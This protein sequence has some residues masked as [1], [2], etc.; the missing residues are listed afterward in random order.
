MLFFYKNKKYLKSLLIAILFFDIFF[1]SPIHKTIAQMEGFG[2]AVSNLGNTGGALGMPAAGVSESGLGLGSTAAPTG[3][4]VQDKMGIFQRVLKTIRDSW[5]QMGVTLHN[6]ADSVKEYIL[7]PLV[8]TAANVI[9]DKFSDSLVTWIQ[10]GFEGSPMFLSDPEGF[11]KDTANDISGAIIND[12]NMNWLCDSLG[13][14][15][16]DLTFFLPGTSR[17]EYACTFEDIANNFKDIASRDELGDWV[18]VN[19]D[20]N[21]QNIVRRFGDD[22]RNGGFWMWLATPLPKNNQTGRIMTGWEKAAIASEEAK[23]RGKFGLSINGGF[24]GMRKCV[25]YEDIQ[26]AM[27]NNKEAEC[28][29]YVNTTP[30]SL[31]QDQLNNSA[32]KDLARLQVA[33]EIDEIIGA[34]ATTM[35]GWLLT[36]GNNNEGVLGYDSGAEYSGS[37]RD[38]YGELSKS[39]KLT[40]AKSNISNQITKTEELESGY[41][42]SLE[43]YSEALYGTKEKLQTVLMYLECVYATS[44]GD[45]TYNYSSCN[46]DIESIGK[47]LSTIDKTSNDVSVDMAKIENEISNI[48]GR[49]SVFNNTYGT[50]ATTTSAITLDIL[51]EFEESVMMASSQSEITNTEEYYCYEY[52]KTN[53]T[54]KIC[55]FFSEDETEKETYTTHSNKDFNKISKEANKIEEKMETVVLK[56]ACLLDEY[57]GDEDV[58]GSECSAV[59]ETSSSASSQ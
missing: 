17:S 56:Y 2:S 45:T 3:I 44:T 32:N 30:G 49:I 8:W 37:N 18:D 43:I 39:Q 23:E 46:D 10:N 29:K 38:H 28:T 5:Y 26:T 35:M 15:R 41:G 24:F 57:T 36:G 13:K 58:T 7:D 1:F 52:N 21:Q 31:V 54:A 34:L 33:D 42:E 40:K 50:N 27:Q 55:G 16:F 59:E 14:F 9:I 12:L 47:N 6:K 51:G 53:K 4:P 48:D 20:V 11:F 22:F 19:V 25:E